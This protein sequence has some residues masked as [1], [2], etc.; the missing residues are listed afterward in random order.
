MSFTHRE[1]NEVAHQLAK[2]ALNCE[3]DMYWIEEG[4]ESIVN[5]MYVVT[6]T[7]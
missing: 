4:P 3:E 2:M 5:Q 7:S 6:N 1:G